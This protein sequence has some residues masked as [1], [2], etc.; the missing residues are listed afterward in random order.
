MSGLLK[1]RVGSMCCYNNVS[2]SAVLQGWSLR[3]T[4][5]HGPGTD[6]I[7]HV[8]ANVAH[9]DKAFTVKVCCTPESFQEKVREGAL[10]FYMPLL[11]ELSLLARSEDCHPFCFRKDSTDKLLCHLGRGFA[12]LGPSMASIEYQH[13]C[14]CG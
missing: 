1:I 9:G 11:R 5:L 12:D 2:D 6:F 7:G 4:V 10:P 3:Q 13:F 8:L 14:S